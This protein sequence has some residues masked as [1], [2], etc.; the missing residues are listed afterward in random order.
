M[1][2]EHL[3]GEGVRSGIIARIWPIS[4]GIY[5]A[6]LREIPDEVAAYH[7]IREFKNKRVALVDR[8][9]ADHLDGV[10]HTDEDILNDLQI[11]A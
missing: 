3:R 10:I 11:Q 5:K 1:N 9:I 2:I 8:Y 4:Q 6:Y 7:F